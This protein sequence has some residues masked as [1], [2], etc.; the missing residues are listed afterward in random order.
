MQ[1]LNIKYTKSLPH[2]KVLIAKS[3]TAYK[4]IN[5]HYVIKALSIFP[6]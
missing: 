3:A 6:E 2:I 4:A 5:S 1:I